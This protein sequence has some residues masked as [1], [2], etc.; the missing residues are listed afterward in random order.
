MTHPAGSPRVR[1]DDVRR[2][3]ES[4]DPVLIGLVNE[5][6][7]QPDEPPGAPPREGAPT[8]AKFLAEI[9]RRDER[10]RS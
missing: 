2:A 7:G 9:R 5:L 10:G 6:A 3:W 4:R 1:L 8:F